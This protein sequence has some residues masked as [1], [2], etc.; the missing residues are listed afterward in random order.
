MVMWIEATGRT[1]K[2]NCAEEGPRHAKSEG[3]GLTVQK[4]EIGHVYDPRLATAEYSLLIP[5]MMFVLRHGWY[6]SVR[7]TNVQT[8]MPHVMT[9]V[10][11]P[12]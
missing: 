2:S 5:I 10:P 8:I 3:R 9:T 6:L 12:R 1:A 11:R 7:A 4:L